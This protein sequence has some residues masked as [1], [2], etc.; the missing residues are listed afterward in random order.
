MLLNDGIVTVVMPRTA[1]GHSLTAALF[2]SHIFPTFFCYHVLVSREKS[3]IGLLQVSFIIL[4]AVI[5]FTES[6]SLL[7]SFLGI[8]TLLMDEIVPEGICPWLD[9]FASITG[10]T[11][12]LLHCSILVLTSVLFFIAL[13][14]PVKEKRLHVRKAAFNPLWES[15][16]T[17]SRLEWWLMK[18]PLVVFSTILWHICFRFL[19]QN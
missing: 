6:L 19:W 15:S 3:L 11:S 18:H 5:W 17:K 12:L 14:P 9:G 10:T 8:K 16:K 1:H 7:V 2:I 4:S 13:H